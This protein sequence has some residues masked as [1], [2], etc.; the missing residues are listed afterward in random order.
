MFGTGQE[1]GE[2]VQGSTFKK[3]KGIIP[4]NVISV[5]PD[6]MA[7][8]KLFPKRDITDEP[9]YIF[10]KEGRKSFCFRIYLRMIDPK[11]EEPPIMDVSFWLGDN[12]AVSSGGKV[13]VI[14]VYGDTKW[15]TKEELAA[16]EIKTLGTM[17]PFP[18]K[19]RQAV[20]G[21]E[22]LTRFVRDFLCIKQPFNYK[23]GEWILK[24]GDAIKEC[25]GYF[26]GDDL[27]KLI[28]GNSD[29]IRKYLAGRPDNKIKFLCGIRANNGK[30]YQT[31]YPFSI[32]YNGTANGVNK[33]L[34][35]DRAFGRESDTDYGEYPFPMVEHVL[36]STAVKKE[37]TTEFNFGETP[38]RETAKST[39]SFEDDLPF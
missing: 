7:L 13:Q 20:Q 24:E 11:Q 1:T 37:D 38:A 10:E 15:I 32:S 35:A 23:S 28:S 33:Q 3:Y 2:P 4:F 27:K 9:R 6:I 34:E 21:E 26:E 18:G 22:K 30:E 16:K 39:G 12:F 25:E 14:N 8:K 19:W 17:R 29:P 31:V 5:N 36:S